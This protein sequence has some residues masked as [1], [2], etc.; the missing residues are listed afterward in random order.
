MRRARPLSSATSAA[1]ATGFPIGA[2]A[3]LALDWTAG[4]LIASVWWPYRTCRRC[5]GAGKLRSPSGKA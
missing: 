4:Y 5:H 3:V 1:T 2:V